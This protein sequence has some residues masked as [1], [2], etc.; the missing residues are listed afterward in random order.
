MPEYL[1][2]AGFGHATLESKQS[3]FLALAA[4]VEDES[5]VAFLLEQIRREHRKANHHVYAYALSPSRQYLKCSDDGEPA[6]TAGHPILELLNRGG[7]TDAV[8]VVTRYFGGTL[9]GTGGLIRSY[10]QTAQAALM[11]AGVK[12][13]VLH[14]LVTIQL[15]YSYFGIVQSWLADTAQREAQVQYT[16]QVSLEVPVKVE[17]C[18]RFCRALTDLTGAKAVLSVGRSLYLGENRPFPR[19]GK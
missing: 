4:P 18:E 5:G 6:G 16:D 13:M 9:L 14:T 11:Q 10:G 2:L 8:V 15:D 12:A 7:L 19:P 1:T 3:L 17:D